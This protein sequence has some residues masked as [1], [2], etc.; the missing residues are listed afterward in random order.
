MSWVSQLSQVWN[1]EPMR[2]VNGVSKWGGVRDLRYRV[3][4]SR[5]PSS[6]A[7]QFGA[8]LAPSQVASDVTEVIFTGSLFTS[9]LTESPEK[10]NAA[11][12]DL[13][14]FNPSCT[15][16]LLLRRTTPLTRRKR[17]WRKS[18]ASKG[19]Y[20]ALS[21][22]AAIPGNPLSFSRANE[23]HHHHLLYLSTTNVRHHVIALSSSRLQERQIISDWS[24]TRKRLWEL[25]RP[26]IFW[27]GML[28]VHNRPPGNV[29][30]LIGGL[31]M[32]CGTYRTH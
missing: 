19:L 30:A 15:S 28:L 29:C 9:G 26:R 14:I 16:L 12:T 11:Q 3:E 21:S 8:A 31:R 25:M 4:T 7:V 27:R 2:K 13:I 22:T 17:F 20:Q 24:I 5:A 32:R 10:F 6:C 23:R 1:A 18:L